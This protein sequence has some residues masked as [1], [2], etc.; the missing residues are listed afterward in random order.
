[1]T[2]KFAFLGC[3]ALA[4]V[5]AL[6]A[7]A[8]AET[9]QQAL[10]AAYEN[11]PT[12]A[13]Q[14]AS[15][16]VA[17]EDVPI[18]RSAGLP[19]IEGS[20]TFQE[21]LL[22][23]EPSASGFFSDPDRQIV[24]QLSANVPLVNFGA[25][26]ASVDAAEE[27]VGASRLGLRTTESEL[28]LQVVAAYMD[29]LRDEAAVALNQSNTQVMQ[30]TLE[31]TRER[32]EAGN[33]GPTDVAQAEARLA[34]AESQ[35]ESARAQL[36]TSSENYIRLVGHAPADL[37]VPPALPQLPESSQDAVDIAL[38]N[39]PEFLAAITQSRAA[40]HDVDAAKAQRLPT[41]SAIGG[42][43]QYDYLGSLDAGTGPRN[44]DRGTTAFVGMQ[45]NLPI[46]QGGRLSAQMRQAQA[47]RSVA[48]EQVLEAERALV[49]DTRSAYASWRS[50]ER[51][52]GSAQRGVDA[53]ERALMG[54]VA[55]TTAGLRPL[56][57][58]LNAEQEL[59]NAQVTLLAARRDAYVAGFQL[60]AAMGLAEARDLNFENSLLY[61]PVANFDRI[62]NR[63]LQFA[64]DPEAEPSG[65]GTRDIVMQYSRIEPDTALA[66]SSAMDD[67]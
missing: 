42:I 66:M 30:F 5:L 25:V 44:G 23:G 11:N 7:S 22:K 59:L 27:R 2:G 16:R 52:I 36:I 57:D 35:L 53:N 56:L 17:D 61:D 63:V 46:F 6:P 48:I 31:E 60:L 29:V 40:D 65:T 9:L 18:A 14:R 21:N 45:L 49:A 34:L 58:R 43:N 41:L 51:V 67:R 54:M 24:A 20:A 4:L 19:S 50:A 55:E 47:R 62:N 12:L 8:Q 13:A 37:S 3:G 10:Q 1:M 33:R 38:E 15:V 64:P 39:N 26:G 32:L 28:F